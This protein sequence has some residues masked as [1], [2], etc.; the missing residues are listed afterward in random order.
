[1]QNFSWIKSIGDYLNAALKGSSLMSFEGCHQLHYKLKFTGK[2]PLELLVCLK[3]PFTRIDPFGPVGCYQEYP[4]Q[5]LPDLK[6]KLPQRVK[7]IYGSGADF[8]IELDQSILR[9]SFKDPKGLH[10]GRPLTDEDKTSSLPFDRLQAEQ[11]CAKLRQNERAFILRDYIRAE[12]KR[13]KIL[14]QLENEKITLPDFIEQQTRQVHWIM[15]HPQA[16]HQA[17]FE[18]D[19]YK[20]A[21]ELIQKGYKTIKKLKKRLSLLEGLIRHYQN[22][23]S[24]KPAVVQK[25][26]Q[27]EPVKGLIFTTHLG[28][29][30]EVGRSARENDRL[31]FHKASGNHYWFHAHNCPGAHVIIYSATPSQEALAKAALLAKFY[32]QEKQASIS[33]VIQT[34][35]KYLKKGNKLGEV[36]VMKK[37]VVQVKHDPTTLNQLFSRIPL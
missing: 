12:K 22:A 30:I 23:I 16:L 21:G 24:V 27:T 10:L 36:N 32:S 1:M 29:K 13:I 5:E 37:K 31:T 4:F 34:Q 11:L 17:P 7:R 33:E 15:Q 20:T 9:F 14:E 8:V 6:N 28:E 3:S 25:K 35:V 19:R 26:Q 2:T 18:I